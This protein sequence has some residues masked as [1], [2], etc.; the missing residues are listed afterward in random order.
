MTGP[1]PIEKLSTGRPM[2]L[3]AEKFMG[4]FGDECLNY[5]VQVD[6]LNKIMKKYSK[7]EGSPAEMSLAIEKDFIKLSSSAY[8]CFEDNDTL[9]LGLDDM[10]MSISSNREEAVYLIQQKLKNN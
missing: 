10:I 7:L 1:I 2:D 8:D 9:S 4:I 5:D 6:Y 3:A